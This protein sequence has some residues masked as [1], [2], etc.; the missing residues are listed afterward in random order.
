MTDT[1]GTPV[2]SAFAWPST[3]DSDGS[4]DGSLGVA[5]PSIGGW[6]AK[7]N[8]PPKRAR[9]EGAE[10]PRPF[11]QGAGTSG[12]GGGGAG[13]GAGASGGYGGARSWRAASSAAATAG[14]ATTPKPRAVPGR[15]RDREHEE[16]PLERSVLRRLYPFLEPL[17]AY[18][19]RILSAANVSL[20]IPLLKP[21][22]PRSYHELLANSVVGRVALPR[23]NNS[24]VGSDDA[25]WPTLPNV[26]PALLKKNMDLRFLVM[27]CIKQLVIQASEAPE[28]Q[29]FAKSV[30]S[31]G[32]RGTRAGSIGVPVPDVPELESYAP[33]TMV[34]NIVQGQWRRLHNRVGDTIMMHLLG[35][36]DVAVFELLRTG[37]YLQAAGVPVGSVISNLGPLVS[38]EQR[39]LQARWAVKRKHS[40]TSAVHASGDPEEEGHS[41]KKSH[42]EPAAG[43]DLPTAVMSPHAVRTAPAR[44]QASDRFPRVRMFYA[45]SFSKRPG[46]PA[47]HLLSRLRSAALRTTATGRA[48]DVADAVWKSLAATLAHSIFVKPTHSSV[49]FRLHR[50]SSVR[51]ASAAPSGAG[52]RASTA[53]PR[54]RQRQ[55]LPLPKRVAARLDVFASV[56]QKFSRCNFAT[57]LLH[58]CPMPRHFRRGM[59]RATKLKRSAGESTQRA[60]GASSEP[61]GRD[62][63]SASGSA[64]VKGSQSIGAVV[65]CG[66]RTAGPGPIPDFGEA[67]GSATE[68]AAQRQSARFGARA[69]LLGDDIASKRLIARTT[70]S[71][72]PSGPSNRAPLPDEVSSGTSGGAPQPRARSASAISEQVTDVPSTRTSDATASTA[73]D[74]LLTPGY[75][76]GSQTIAPPAPSLLSLQVPHAQVSS[77][78]KAVL[79][80]ILPDCFWG[81]KSTRRHLL[82]WVGRFVGLRRHESVSAADVMRGLSTTA[83]PWTEASRLRH[84]G[85]RRLPPNDH[86]TRVN[87]LRDW[88]SWLFS[89][90]VISVVRAHFYVTESEPLRNRTLCFRK[91]VWAAAQRAAYKRLGEQLCLKPIA[92]EEAA[93][94]VRQRSL[95]YARVRL[96]PKLTGVRPIMD[97]S[98]TKQD[99]PRIVK[100]TAA[101]P[102]A[103][104]KR[105]LMA[106]STAGSAALAN[107]WE[108]MKLGRVPSVQS[109]S[110]RP[111]SINAV[112]S[113]THEALK[114]ERSRRRELSGAA[115]FG[116]HGIHGRLQPFIREW[117][118]RG[119]GPGRR[120]GPPMPLFFVSVD[121]SKCYDSMKPDKLLEIIEPMFRSPD[122]TVQRYAV[123]TPASQIT[124]K[125][126]V[127][128][129]YPRV[130]CPEGHDLSFKELA[131]TRTSVSQR[132]VLCDS[133]V[134]PNV[135][136]MSALSLLREHLTSNIVRIG[137][138]FYV[139]QRGI[140]QGS[141]LSTLLCNLYYAHMERTELGDT[142][143]GSSGDRTGSM[144]T[145][146]DVLTSNAAGL[147]EQPLAGSETRS[148]AAGS[149]AAQAD[150]GGR[151]RDAPLS[152]LMR[153]TDDFLL[154]SDTREVAVAF[155]QAM[156]GGFPSYGCEVNPKKT[157]VNFPLT[158][159]LRAGERVTLRRVSGWNVFTGG[160][161][162]DV[163]D[164][165]ASTPWSGA[166]GKGARGAG[167]HGGVYMTP[168]LSEVS[169]GSSK[170]R[171]PHLPRQGAAPRPSLATKTHGGGAGAGAGR[172]KDDA[173]KGTE[174][175]HCRTAD[176]ADVTQSPRPARSVRT[177]DKINQAEVLPYLEALPPEL[178]FGDL[179]PWCGLLFCT[180][181]FAVL[182]NYDRYAAP[183]DMRDSLT[184]NLSNNPGLALAKGLR[185]FVRPKCHAA[186]LD[187]SVQALPVV[188][189]NVYQLSLLAA[190]KLHGT[191]RKLHQPIA[192]NPEFF[193]NVVLDALRYLNALVR[194]RTGGCTS[195][196]EA[197]RRANSTRPSH[198]ADANLWKLGCYCALTADQVMWL[199]L[200]AFCTVL[201][202]KASAYVPH[203]LL[204]EVACAR[205]AHPVFACRY[206]TVIPQLRRLLHGRKLH[207]ASRPV[208]CATHPGLSAFLRAMRF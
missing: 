37:C 138:R 122:Y 201:Q 187:S 194:L 171:F 204:N 55:Q 179:I 88:I 175:A 77:F 62:S 123:V 65:D 202:R 107:P 133:V 29:K 99:F 109:W 104:E 154:V 80:Q 42:G 43:K 94:T 69:M 128:A 121:V 23:T 19:M 4:D 140:P 148:Q 180:K 50:S 117:R 36:T 82:R 160:D 161:D 173:V 24:A 188:A 98:T 208:R 181:T 152:L 137:N 70:T 47:G 177:P 68:V 163:D 28:R 200:H 118:R 115:V 135:N 132:A 56:L 95:G 150:A 203:R 31:L 9:R 91:S 190:A 195:A 58:H 176:S 167:A 134:Y 108:V 120:A 30:L 191:A 207:E 74:Q 83:F 22:D 41:A 157:L 12:R 54:A 10:Q 97:L 143:V 35:D 197:A 1:P 84:V 81:N 33:N 125:G 127:R 196:E 85:K 48:S 162:E 46:L 170:H 151:H 178:R 101:A 185:A 5:L 126:G 149:P 79:R 139:Q 49:G 7:S 93:A 86:T 156:L 63:A 106:S 3:G 165:P 182:A 11:S 45:P 51:P 61:A 76:P 38:G 15:P 186:L 168:A 44:L 110:R 199:G 52:V 59:P 184:V 64:P 116:V 16:L 141:V 66:A 159:S 32:Y 60:A 153:L 189:L 103:G 147:A 105:P 89:D 13:A 169:D 112:L 75:G 198:Q 158:V 205:L 145:L 124:L 119:S 8:P 17:G 164:S 6:R 73:R 129:R 2:V 114:F 192:T 67:W 14:S 34:D 40:A 136:R 131:E 100:Q 172:D 90:L 78:V 142:P 174:E 130:V 27:R 144:T 102:V 146:R 166:S 87:L 96:L 155:A 72:M 111:Y 113:N 18:V 21:D 71:A 193:I 206:R 20:P 57:L 39:R 53:Q 26:A 183:H 25:S 92:S